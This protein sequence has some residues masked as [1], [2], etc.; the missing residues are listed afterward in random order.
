MS[1]KYIEKIE[2]TVLNQ[3][4]RTKTMKLSKNQLCMAGEL[5]VCAELSKRAHDV[6][7]TMGN[8]KAI[9]LLVLMKNGSYKRIEVKTT[10]SKNV[11]T[12]FFQKYYNR[13]LPDHPDYWV[14][15]FIDKSYNS[16]YY[17][18]SHDEMGDVQMKRNNMSKWGQHTGV[19]NVPEQLV[20]AYKDMWSTIK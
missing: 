12:G 13:A 5:G 8:T 9:D 16:H 2:I 15:V 7:I 4:M 17:V 20:R 18:L 10:Q 3:N 19:D 11:V 14:L 1:D 6:M